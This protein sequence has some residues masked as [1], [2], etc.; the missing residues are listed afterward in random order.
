MSTSGRRAAEWEQLIS[1]WLELKT[2][3]SESQ[4]T[5]RG[6]AT[7]MKRWREFLVVQTPPPALW[8]ADT[9]HVRAWQQAMRERGLRETT[10]NHELSCVS[11]FYSFVGGERRLVN[12]RERPVFVDRDGKPRANPFRMGNVQRGRTET[13]ERARYLSRREVS[14]LLSYLEAQSDTVAGA[15]NYALILT[16]IW[17]GWRSAELLRMR[18]GDVRPSRSQQGDYVYAWQGKG[19]K[20]QDD[21]LPGDCWKAI[22][23]YLT[24]AR[25]Y[26]P[27]QGTAPG[28]DE[29]VWLPV[30]TPEMDGMRNGAQIVP[31][32]PISERTA[33][34]VLR[35]ALKGAGIRDAERIRVHDLRHT[36][37][38]FLLDAGVPLPDVQRRLHHKSLATTGLY[39]RI[40]H[41]ED[42]VDNFSN[43]FR[44]MRSQ[45]V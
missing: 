22:C 2:A 12:G 21:V 24:K 45:A 37:A 39:V 25:R 23:A 14:R 32:R 41:H 20:R 13:Y 26:L 33:L 35:T 29:P 27:G 28:R 1:D 31:G 4:H 19:G 10:I 43:A 17:T 44:Q 15:R 18:W 8:E 34:R 30:T 16:Y 38:H 40:V 36:H 3:R 11:S 7:A 6:Y 5:R 42:P 9:R